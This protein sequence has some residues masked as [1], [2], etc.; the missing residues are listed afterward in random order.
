METPEDLGITRANGYPV[1]YEQIAS[2]NEPERTG[3]N[4]REH[5]W[6]SA[7]IDIA[8]MGVPAWDVEVDYTPASDAA[9]F[10]TT[11][12]GLHL[13]RTN[14]GPVYGNATDPDDSTQTIWRLY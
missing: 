2:G 11:A 13:T 7:L 3:W 6:T 1:S 10:V 5:E 12:T 9:C 8:A 4:Q 14:T